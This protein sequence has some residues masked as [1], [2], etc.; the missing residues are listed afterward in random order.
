M[1]ELILT[2][3]HRYLLDGKRI[4]GL[5]STI[6]EAGLMGNFGSEWHMDRGMKIHL[7]TEL[8]DKGTLDESTVDP[9]I[10]GYLESWKQF[11]KDQSYIPAHIEYPTYHP[12]LMVGTKID[13]VPLLDIKS[14][15]P[16]PWHI[17]QLA[18]QWTTLRINGP[19]GYAYTAIN[20]TPKDIYLD[21]DGGPPKVKTYTPA[22][23]RE[24]FKIYA[25]MLVYLR[26]RREKYGT[27]KVNG[28]RSNPETT[29]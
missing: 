22:E 16:E 18:F 20:W 7:A 21:P 8:W 11:R 4:D 3:D 2:D 6:Q 26:W 9:Q 25:S 19:N 14:G 17:L 15:S 5:T 29:Y 28:E 24:S 13:R 23:M 12:E 27:S 10:Q 1:S